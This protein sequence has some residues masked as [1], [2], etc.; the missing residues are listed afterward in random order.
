MKRRQDLP[1]YLRLN[2]KFD[3]EKLRKAFEDC[4]ENVAPRW[5]PISIKCGG[6]V[7]LDTDTPTYQCYH[8]SKFVDN[9]YKQFGSTKYDERN[10]SGLQ[11]WVKGTYFE[12]VLSSFSDDPCR[13]RIL[14]MN[15][16]GKLLPHIDYNTDYNVR[17]HIPINTN[18]WAMFG[19]RRK[20]SDVDIFNMPADGSCYFINQGW[21]HSAWNLGK[22]PRDHIVIAL[23]S[24]KDIEDALS[25]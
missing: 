24:Q 5:D 18:P 8:L 11:D 10:Y 9:G 1:N 25:A 15:P 20:D 12:E 3:I 17:I 7:H 2:Q 6:H 21:E 13:A 14:S 22:T 4:K 23:R 16:G 19:I